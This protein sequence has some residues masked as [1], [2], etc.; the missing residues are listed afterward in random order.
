MIYSTHNI[1]WA[2]FEKFVL[3]SPLELHKKSANLAAERPEFEPVW[4]CAGG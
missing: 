1:M 4:I 3:K 2:F